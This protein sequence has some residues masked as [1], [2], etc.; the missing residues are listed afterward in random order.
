M[1]KLMLSLLLAL[2]FAA[3]A[4]E[5]PD[6]K[7]DSEREGYKILATVTANQLAQAR[8]NLRNNNA[9][10]DA[11]DELLGDEH[12]LAENSDG[13]QSE[14]EADGE[15][16]GTISVLCETLDEKFAAMVTRFGAQ[17]DELGNRLEGRVSALETKM[18][19]VQE[20]LAVFSVQKKKKEKE[21]KKGTDA[22]FKELKRR[23]RVV[24]VWR[25]SLL[26]A[27]REAKYSHEFNTL[28]DATAQLAQEYSQQNFDWKNSQLVGRSEQR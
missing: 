6:T 21:S 5:D 1:K 28:C 27:D 11:N 25:V 9:S 13:E 2:P 18:T 19:T 26:R 16:S 17:M 8:D 7:P 23:G 10:E 4:M 15:L 3:F 24:E 12:Q 22:A 20:Q 14:A